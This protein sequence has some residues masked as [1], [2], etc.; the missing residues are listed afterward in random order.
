MLARREQL[1]AVLEEIALSSWAAETV[2]RLRCLRGIS[3]LSVETVLD[4]L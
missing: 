3:S 2:T 1:E 4:R